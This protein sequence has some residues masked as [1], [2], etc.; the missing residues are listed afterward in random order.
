MHSFGR[1]GGLGS[2]FRPQGPQLLTLRLQAGR[3]ACCAV[4]N[5]PRCSSPLGGEAVRGLVVGSARALLS[6]LREVG[7]CA[8]AFLQKGWVV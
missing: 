1:S 5:W 7:G 3:G 2:L 6:F 8:R 4:V